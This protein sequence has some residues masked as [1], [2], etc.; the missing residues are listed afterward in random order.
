MS[1]DNTGVDNYSIYAGGV[2]GDAVSI[3]NSLG[4]SIVSNLVSNGNIVTALIEDDGTVSKMLYHKTVALGGVFGRATNVAVDS[5]ISNANINAVL[6]TAAQDVL[7]IGGFVGS[8]IQTNG[9]VNA[10]IRNSYSTGV[11]EVNTSS[12]ISNGGVGGF[13]GYISAQTEN[14]TITPGSD[15]ASIVNCYTISRVVTTNTTVF[16]DKETKVLIIHYQYLRKDLYL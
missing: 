14:K 15:S 3:G 9:G 6:P 8:F 4:T 12:Y 7:Y 5:A 11:I 1:K 13:V 10:T 16:Y 2:V